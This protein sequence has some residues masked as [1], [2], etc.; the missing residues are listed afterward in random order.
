MIIFLHCKYPLHNG[1]HS[2]KEVDVISLRGAWAR[3]PIIAKASFCL[4]Q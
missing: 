1:K 2:G 3:V 4:E